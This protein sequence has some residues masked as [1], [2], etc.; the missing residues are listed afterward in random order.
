MS[1]PVAISSINLSP[2]EVTST[3]Q[4]TSVLSIEQTT[5]TRATFKE[6]LSFLEAYRREKEPISDET[7]EAWWKMAKSLNW[8]LETF[9][10]VVNKV[11]DSQY[12]VT[13]RDIFAEH[14][15]EKNLIIM[16]QE[17]YENHIATVKEEMAAMYRKKL[18]DDNERIRR[19]YFGTDA[20]GKQAELNKR[21]MDLIRREAAITKKEAL[22][23][24]REDALNERTKELLEKK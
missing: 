1:E 3:K 19:E 5:M 2:E 18:A 24:K 17:R 16:T 14:L 11:K 13:G 10:Q 12:P 23:L 4:L 6:V 15:Q 8:S 22:L 20:G 7:A 21:E 9:K